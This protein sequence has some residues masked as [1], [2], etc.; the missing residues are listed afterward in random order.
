MVEGSAWEHRGACCGCG[1]GGFH[2]LHQVDACTGW[3]ASHCVLLMGGGQG[4][5][6]FVHMWPLGM[7]ELWS[8][9]GL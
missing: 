2:G 7:A 6:S 3:G 4:S 1:N 9:W 8:S 5:G